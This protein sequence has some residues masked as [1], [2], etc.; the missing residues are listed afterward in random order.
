M[1][2]TKKAS[3]MG[4]FFVSESRFALSD[5]MVKPATKVKPPEKVKRQAHYL[6]SQVADTFLNKDFA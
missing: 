4:G 2:I 1:T 5:V 3:L 6:D